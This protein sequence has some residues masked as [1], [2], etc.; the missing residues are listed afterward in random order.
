MHHAP[1]HILKNIQSLIK[2][3]EAKAN[4]ID[5]KKL[6]LKIYNN[7]NEKFEVTEKKLNFSLFEKSYSSN[8]PVIEYGKNNSLFSTL[9]NL[10]H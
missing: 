3:Q 4:G 8:I 9:I 1:K 2:L 5:I 10:L 7:K 6:Y